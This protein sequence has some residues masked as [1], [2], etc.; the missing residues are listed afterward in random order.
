MKKEKKQK[1]KRKK[2]KETGFLGFSNVCTHKQGKKDMKA[3]PPGKLK[4]V[5]PKCIRAGV[6]KLHHVALGYI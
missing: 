6:T 5:E 2:K 4:K 1:Q 3:I